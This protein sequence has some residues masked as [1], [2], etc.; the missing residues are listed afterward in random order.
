MQEILDSLNDITGELAKINGHLGTIDG[1]LDK[2]DGR[3]D[4]IDGRLD[5]IDGRLD[6]MDG[7]LDTMDGRL[8][9]LDERVGTLEQQVG[10]GFAR[11]D[12][13]LHRHGVLLESMNSDLKQTMEVVVANREATDRGFAA[14][15]ETLDQRVQ[16][17]ELATRDL[18]RQLAETTKAK[19]R[20]G[21]QG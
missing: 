16:P 3:L 18:G 21:R 20:A 13:E 1:R 17:V 6:T 10:A 15:L 19:R 7:R 5:T 8:D 9:K 12:A 4:T 2:V 14:I 11:V